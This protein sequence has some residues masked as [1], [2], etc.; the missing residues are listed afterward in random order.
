MQQ[1]IYPCPLQAENKPAM[2]TAAAQ[3]TEHLHQVKEPPA[4]VSN[5]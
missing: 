5:M 3:H 1:N 4:S 2:E